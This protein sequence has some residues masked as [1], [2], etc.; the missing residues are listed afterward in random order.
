MNTKKRFLLT[1]LIAIMC[2][3]MLATAIACDKDTDD[4]TDDTDTSEQLFTN[5]DFTLTTGEIG[6]AHV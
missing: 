1:L 6:R 3:V 5:G 4:N 2:I